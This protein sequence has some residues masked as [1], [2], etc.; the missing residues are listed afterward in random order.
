MNRKGG[1]FTSPKRQSFPR[2]I[3]GKRKSGDSNKPKKEDNMAQ[4]NNQEVR[5]GL[6]DLPD[7]ILIHILLFTSHCK[8]LQVSDVHVR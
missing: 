1:Q 5:T 7:E 3:R 2:G 8:I 6:L 4:E